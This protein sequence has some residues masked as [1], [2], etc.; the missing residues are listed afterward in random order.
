MRKRKY[1]LR[2]ELSLAVGPGWE[3]ESDCEAHALNAKEASRDNGFFC[4]ARYEPPRAGVRSQRLGDRLLSLTR[5]CHS[6]SPVGRVGL[7]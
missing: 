5:G 4:G 3:P 6:V 1:R 7:G 2:V